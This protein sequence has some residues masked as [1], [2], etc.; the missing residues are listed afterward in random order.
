M[1]I[2]EII[3]PNRKNITHVAIVLDRSTSMLEAGKSEAA[4]SSFNEQVDQLRLSTKENMET[5]VSLVTFST[6]VDKTKLWKK[7]INTIKKIDKESYSPE[8]W[9][10]LYDA[11]GYTASRFQE[12]DKGDKNTA[13]LIVVIT[14]GEENF[15]KEYSGSKL[16]SLISECQGSGRFTFVYMGTNVDLAKVAGELNI[17]IWN[18]IAYGN[19]GRGLYK[20]ANVV[21]NA[22]I[23]YMQ[24]RS[25]GVTADSAM[26][27]QQQRDEAEKSD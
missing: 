3:N 7:D 26:F 5:T 15:S 13:Y 11:V 24:S 16:A 2:P 14:D 17:P 1:K 21:N 12:E 10:A 27:T 8:G 20:T 18:T 4:I 22:T 6:Q 9:T 19:S 25:A 23:N